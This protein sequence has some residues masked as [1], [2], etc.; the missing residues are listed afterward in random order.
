MIKNEVMR[1]L[2]E[3]W[4]EEKNKVVSWLLKLLINVTF[5]DLMYHPAGVDTV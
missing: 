2:D 3:R 4:M 1:W 5:T